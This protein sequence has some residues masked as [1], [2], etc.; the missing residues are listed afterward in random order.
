MANEMPPIPEEV[1][2]QL[3]AALVATLVAQLRDNPALM[4]WA[5]TALL[6]AINRR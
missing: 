6:S 5:I 1:L 2:K 3:V 4:Q